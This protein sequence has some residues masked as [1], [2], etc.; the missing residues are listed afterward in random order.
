[1]LLYGQHN[2]AIGYREV[3]VRFDHGLMGLFDTADMNLVALNVNTT[4]FTVMLQVRP[5]SYADSLRM[6]LDFVENLFLGFRQ[7][8]FSF[9]VEF[10]FPNSIQYRYPFTITVFIMP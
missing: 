4:H 8:I 9:R 10:T 5:P 7:Y 6:L 1:V 3:T 2:M